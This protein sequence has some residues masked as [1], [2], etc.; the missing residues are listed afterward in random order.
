ME[1]TSGNSLFMRGEILCRIPDGTP[2]ICEVGKLLREGKFRSSEF[3]IQEHLCE[4]QHFGIPPRVVGDMIRNLHF[5]MPEV[6]IRISQRCAQFD[7]MLHLDNEEEYSISG[8]PRS[9]VG[10]GAQ[11]GKHTRGSSSDTV[12]IRRR[13]QWTPPDS[14]RYSSF[15]SAIQL[16]DGSHSTHLPSSASITSVTTDTP[17]SRL[18]SAR[19]P[20]ELD[21]HDARDPRAIQE[22]M[23]F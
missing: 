21:A 16:R 23:R 20:Q 11:I 8:F 5:R 22:A 12:G 19:P 10:K 14:A 13:P 6:K 1:K 2:E 7:V 4:R 3:I 18:S 9:I 17:A 15:D